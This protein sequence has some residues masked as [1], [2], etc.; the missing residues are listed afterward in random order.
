MFIFFLDH[1]KKMM[2]I[3]KGMPPERSK[4]SEEPDHLL[5][6]MV[7]CF[8]GLSFLLSMLVLARAELVL[9]GTVLVAVGLALLLDMQIRRGRSSAN[10]GKKK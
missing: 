7:F 2:M 3:A 4:T 9:P 1:Q 5:A 10:G 6:G 8:I